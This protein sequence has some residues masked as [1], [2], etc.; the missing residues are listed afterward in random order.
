MNIEA[1]RQ[2]ADTLE[3]GL[4]YPGMR[5]YHDN[6]RAAIT[7]LRTAIA[8]AEKQEPV[9][10]MDASETALSWE[11]YLD[12]MKPLYT[13]PPAAQP[14]Q[15]EPDGVGWLRKDGGY[16]NP[17]T[18]QRQWVGLTDA[19][20]AEWDYDVRDVVMDIEKLLKEKNT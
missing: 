7:A 20:I 14:E 19:E 11:N 2:A 16:F 8:E 13:A 12:G 18:V 1:M 4:A 15:Q 5:F 6:I 10:W 9:A 3:I 17:P